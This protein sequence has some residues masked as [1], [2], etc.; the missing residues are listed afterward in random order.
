MGIERRSQEWYSTACWTKGAPPGSRLLFHVGELGEVLLCS[1]ASFDPGRDVSLTRPSKPY[2][3]YGCR[4][5]VMNARGSSAARRPS[6]VRGVGRRLILAIRPIARL[7][8]RPVRKTQVDNVTKA[9]CCRPSNTV[10]LCRWLPRRGSRNGRRAVEV[11]LCV[12]IV[13]RLVV[14]R[15]AVT[16]FGP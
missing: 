14:D 12:R 2:S 3:A 16:R 4:V 1:T 15:P 11:A 13:V 6:H 5:V 10:Q 7:Y 9:R 8:H